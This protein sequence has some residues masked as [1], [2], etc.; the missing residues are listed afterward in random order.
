MTSRGRCPA[1]PFEPVLIALPNPQREK[2]ERKTKRRL[3]Q[4]LE[5]AVVSDC[6]RNPSLGL[7]DADLDWPYLLPSLFL[8]RVQNTFATWAVLSLLRLSDPL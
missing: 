8:L 4:E 5:N 3:E 2:A 1:I 6:G 7:I